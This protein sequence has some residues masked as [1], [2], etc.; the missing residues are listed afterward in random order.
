MPLSPAARHY[1]NVRRDHSEVGHPEGLDRELQE[2]ST[3]DGFAF[4]DYSLGLFHHDAS[5]AAIE[6]CRYDEFR[7]AAW[8]SLLC[9]LDC[10]EP[11]GKV[12][13][14]ELPYKTRDLEAAKPVLGHFAAVLV[15]AGG[16]DFL[17]RMQRF[18]VLP[19][20]LA[21]L[22]VL[23]RT[24]MGGHGLMLTISSRAS[25][26][27]NDILSA[28][29]PSCTVEGPDTN[30]LLVREYRSVA[31][32]ASRLGQRDLAQR[33]TERADTIIRNME[34]LMWHDDERGGFYVGLRWRH[35]VGSL[36]G[37]IVSTRD[38]S[39]A[40]QPLESWTGLLPLY[41]GVPSPAR[42]DAIVRRLTDPEG[43]WSPVGVR[44]APAWSEYFHQAPR[45][46]CW[47]DRKNQAGPVSNW[48][49]PVWVL[50]NWYLVAGLERYGY[51]AQAAELA[52][53]TVGMLARDLDSTGMLHECYADDGRGLW[54][55]RGTFVSWNVLA[56]DLMRRHLL[57]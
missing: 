22:E 46:M 43:Y 51:H 48:V 19:R 21:H 3:G 32:L 41:A 2:P 20:V 37:E 10:A 31:E 8:G 13:R 9:F 25:G 56:L 6:L 24:L 29:L 45:V 55:R 53:N 40:M 36:D 38:A 47:D 11:G 15:E 35:G 39:G 54:P 34:R 26:F 23:E 42:A 4:G 33:M 17:D 27:D 44:T 1:L 16:D 14:T 18:E 5:E 52:R 49:G 28:G 7:E 12:H 57:Q 50:S 30:A